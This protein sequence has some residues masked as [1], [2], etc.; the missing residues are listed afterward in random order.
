MRRKK[1]IVLAIPL[2]LAF[3]LLFAACSQ[4]TSTTDN[5]GNA[6]EPS[7]ETPAESESTAAEQTDTSSEPAPEAEPLKVRLST[8]E[9]ADNPFNADWLVWDYLSE[10]SGVELEPF[11]IA[12]NDP[13]EAYNTM[14]ATRDLP[15]LMFFHNYNLPNRFGGDGALVN[16]LDH[17]DQMPNM[18]AWL[19]QF[20][21]EASTAM[22][23]DG[24]MYVTPNKGIADGSRTL[25]MYREDVFQQLGLAPPTTYDELYEVLKQ[26]KAAY[27]DSYPH[28]WRFGLAGLEV[29][30]SPNFQTGQNFY[31]NFDRNEWAFGPIEDNYKLMVEFIRK[32]NDEKL[33]PPD[34]PTL[35]TNAWHELI[36]TNR[37]FIMQDYIARPGLLIGQFGEQVEG[38]K[39]NWLPPLTGV[40]GGQGK[41]PLP[42][43]FIGYS[44]AADTENLTAALTFIDY[45]FSEDGRS[46][47][48]W[49][50][51]GETYT[52]LNGKKSL[53][54]QNVLELRNDTGLSTLGTYLWFDFSAH[55]SMLPDWEV[56]MYAEQPK[57]ESKVQ[58][59]PAMTAEEAEVIATKGA[60]IQKH[61]DENIVRFMLGTRP[62]SEWDQYVEEINN[63][64]VEEVRQIYSTA[65]ARAQR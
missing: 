52:E 19:E 22:A 6:S 3:A 37:A 16:L 15:D 29:F 21:V 27:P 33:I 18:K 28:A 48:S 7:Q 14:F 56:A 30:Y 50:K 20:P 34:W 1:P 10:G 64:G 55:T 5:A 36:G 45:L 54:F 58:P 39:M 40:P 63:L 41:N 62:M 4:G 24:A 43:N 11:S 51:Q 65:Y 53:N 46:I 26:L 32:L 23:A 9:Y 17:L 31:Y 59:R 44:V 12:T 35:D 49:G 57:Y 42:H 2:L 38:F 8:F 25:W 47:A 61:K 13:T 60:A